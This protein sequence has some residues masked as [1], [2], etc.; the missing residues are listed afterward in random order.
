MTHRSPGW[1]ATATRPVP[2]GQCR[3]G[4]GR[5]ESVYLVPAVQ[6]GVSWVFSTRTPVSA[7][8]LYV[9]SPRAPLARR[10]PVAPLRRF[11]PHRRS[12]ES[13]SLHQ[14]VAVDHRQAN[15]GAPGGIGQSRPG[16]DVGREM[17]PVA[18]HEDQVGALADLDRIRFQ[19]SMPSARA[20]SRVAIQSAS[21]AVSAPG[22]CRTACRVAASRISSNMSSRLLQAAPSAPSETEIPR[23]RISATG[24]IPEPSFRLEPGQCSTFTSRSASNSCSR[25]RHPDAMRGAE[26]RRREARVGQILE[27]AEA[28]RQAAHDLDLVAILRRVRVH[29]VR[30]RAARD[31][32]PPSS[33]SREHDTAKRGANAACSRPSA[34]PSQRFFSARLSSIECARP[35]LQ[36]PRHLVGPNPSCTCRRPRACRCRRASRTRRRCRGP[37]PSSGRWSCPTAAAPRRRGAS[38]ARSVAGVCAASIGQT[39]RFSQSSSGMS[40]A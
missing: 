35:L 10:P 28:T 29:E 24:A 18:L 19:S 16:I 33:S 30:L 15:V 36:P 38:T 5:R 2:P 23:C 7:K 9:R 31:A 39:R 17:R 26:V 21:C 8:P 25:V 32:P 11:L 20:P 4:P 37:S 12:R 40:S 34:A 27:I 6:D 1:R 13:K 14:H 3:P 22:A